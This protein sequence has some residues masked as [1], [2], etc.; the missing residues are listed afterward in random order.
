MDD[1]LPAPWPLLPKGDRVKA[2]QSIRDVYD[3]AGLAA[4]R[5][6]VWLAGPRD[7]YR[8]LAWVTWRRWVLSMALVLGLAVS[9]APLLTTSPAGL[10]E[11]ASSSTRVPWIGSAMVLALAG[12]IGGLD[13]RWRDVRHRVH[14]ARG[15]CLLILLG[16]ATAAP[17]VVPQL[18]AVS[19][20]GGGIA[21]LAL[22]GLVT[23]P[24]AGSA[25]LPHRFGPLLNA[26]MSDLLKRA[27]PG[28]RLPDTALHAVVRWLRGRLMPAPLCPAE[29]CFSGQST[30]ARACPRPST[31]QRV[32]IGLLNHVGA[33]W[34]Y[35]N[36]ALVLAPPTEC[37]V[38]GEGALHNST[39]AAVRW[40][41]G[42][43]LL[44]IDGE[45][46]GDLDL[47]LD[48]LSAEAVRQ[49]PSPALRRVLIECF[50]PERLMRAFGGHK[51]AEDAA[52]QL[53]CAPQFDGEPLV[54]VRVR[55]ATPEPDGQRRV[56]WLR[57]PPTTATP[58]EGVAW[59]FG[60]DADAYRPT[61]ET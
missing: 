11:A 32:A 9:V 25:P 59:T 26:R 49:E 19:A 36:V 2:E 53:W 20:A 7:A 50:G 43:V 12:L 23:P 3:A 22:G 33:L 44:A 30:T 10:G 47:D 55:N 24:P 45:V 51:I 5:F 28:P 8:V 42:T 21:T 48:R 38:N 14:T 56:Y 18:S 27:S 35:R 39:G 37:H 61:R 31:M 4:P 54:M 60:L 13:W 41:D 52:G 58:R 16:A 29:A 1:G 34:M 46:G 17:F 40:A 6:I 15:A 57:V